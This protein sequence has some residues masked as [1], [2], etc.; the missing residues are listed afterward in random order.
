MNL[1]SLIL[2][3]CALAMDAFS[4]SL[5]KG[6]GVKHI[7]FKHYI[8]VGVYFG[9]FQ[10]L[11]PMI[12]YVIG[13]EFG[14]FVEH[15]DHWIAFVLLG[16]IGLK[17]IKESR[18]GNSCENISNQFG[19]KTMLLLAIAT[20]IDA[21]AIG[22]TL[23]FLNANILFSIFLIGTITFFFCIVALKI[24]NTFG[25]FLKDKAEL[26]GGIVLIALGVKILIEHL[27]F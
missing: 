6:F 7:T 1:I 26:C 22:I 10:A 3:A 4:V 9:G 14:G 17:M 11:M 19:V 20:S 18:E 23:A 15:I 8:I 2:L 27:C 5:C 12:G 16:I 21:F 25:V 13:V 24:G